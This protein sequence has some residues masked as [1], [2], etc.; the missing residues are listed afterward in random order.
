MYLQQTPVSWPNRLPPFPVAGGAAS[1]HREMGLGAK[2][3]L[4]ACFP[5]HFAYSLWFER[6]NPDKKQ[7]KGRWNSGFSRFHAGKP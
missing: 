7:R 5:R 3:R 4:A 2:T 6:Q 1:R